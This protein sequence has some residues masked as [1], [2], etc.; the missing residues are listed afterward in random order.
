MVRQHESKAGRHRSPTLC[1]PSGFPICDQ[2][3]RN[4]RVGALGGVVDCVNGK[5]C[6]CPAP[7]R[8]EVGLSTT[9]FG[10]ILFQQSKQF[11]CDFQ[12]LADF[13]DGTSQNVSRRDVRADLLLELPPQ[14][15]GVRLRNFH[16]D[17]LQATASCF[18]VFY[19]E[20]PCV[21]GIRTYDHFSRSQCGYRTDAFGCIFGLLSWLAFGPD[22]AAPTLVAV[23]TCA[24]LDEI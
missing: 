10:S 1:T 11:C 7:R 20:R 24:M 15:L 18:E 6:P 3:A 14:R 17:L 8:T 16:L 13:V 23:R 2:R 22:A 5:I 4:I 9:V 21:Q 12:R 19:Y